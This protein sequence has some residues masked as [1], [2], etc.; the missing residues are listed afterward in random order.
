MDSDVFTLS[1]SNF[2]FG[3]ELLTKEMEVSVH[4]KTFIRECVI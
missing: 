1:I 3:I 2:D 4:F